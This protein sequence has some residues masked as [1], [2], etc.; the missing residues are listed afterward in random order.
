[1]TVWAKHLW[2]KTATQSSVY[3]QVAGAYL[4]HLS[5]DRQPPV[6]SDSCKE[7]LS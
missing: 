7:A 5:T 1:M 6:N 3:A 2:A 4:L